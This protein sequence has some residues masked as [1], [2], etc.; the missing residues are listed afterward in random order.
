MYISPEAKELHMNAKVIDIHCHPSLK[1]ELFGYHI[2][3]ENH[4]NPSRDFSVFSIDHMQVDL[5]KLKRGRTDCIFSTI[6]VPERSFIDNCVLFNAI[7]W[8]IQ[9]LGPD[10]HSKIE[11]RTNEGAFNQ[12]IDA[13]TR[14]ENEVLH[15]SNQ[16]ERV[17]VPKTYTEF[18]DRINKGD[19]C[20]LHALEG[21]HHLGKN[22]DDEIK[23]WNKLDTYI[24]K[25]VCLITPAHFVENDFVY[26]ANGIAPG[27]KEMLG[28]DYDYDAIKDKGLKPLGR[29]LIEKMLDKGVIVDL[30]HLTTAERDEV[31]QMNNDRGENKRPLVFSHSGVRAKCS[32]ELLTPSDDEI[33]KIRD[34][35]GTIGIIAMKYWLNGSE[36]EP[37]YSLY[38][39]IDT[40]KHIAIVCGNY[41]HIS[42]GTDFDGFTE[43]CD[44]IYSGSDLVKLTQAMMENSIDNDDIIK[45]LGENTMRVLKNGWGNN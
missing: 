15:A 27:T 12:A 19:I 14:V 25:G 9:I 40:M 24:Q 22:F 5:P 6:Y 33:I 1:M 36:K 3:N 17:I 10:M 34:C 2:Y 7:E 20:F 18:E 43:P 16:G 4:P 21:A 23:Y 32:N 42:I 35:G 41:D 37:D 45:V 38:E 39:M 44:D 30:T 8:L 28:F 13:I 11:R 26:P 31:F 29:K